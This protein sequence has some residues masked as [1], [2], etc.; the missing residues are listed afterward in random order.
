MS[1]SQMMPLLND[2]RALWQTCFDDDETFVDF[3]FEHCASASETIVRYQDGLPIGHIGL[4]HY[5]IAISPSITINAI[6]ISGA[7]VL[8]EYRQHGV[9]RQ[10]MTELIQS[11]RTAE[12]FFLIP[13][14]SELRS[15]YQRTFG[16]ETISQRIT[17][18]VLPSVMRPLPHS[19]S[20]SLAD[21][22]ALSRHEVLG[23]QHSPRQINNIIREYQLYPYTFALH[24][25]GGIALGRKISNTLYIDYL[26]GSPK[27]LET[28]IDCDLQ[29]KIRINK[30][31]QDGQPYT[32]EPWGMLRPLNLM[33]WLEVWHIN[34]PNETYSFSYIDRL[35]P[36]LSGSY[37]INNSGVHFDSRQRLHPELSLTKFVQLFVPN[38]D[39]ALLHE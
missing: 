11:E 25:Q 10:M 2:A 32:A 38:L 3:Y 35:L 24:D 6:Y 4:P 23:I 26:Y 16:F 20:Q 5:H 7:C 33:P 12:A 21:T 1:A 36:H 22:L 27:A 18:S 28:L 17:S 15:Y 29:L 13:A 37:T 39:L 9:M 14:S 34:N 30:I 31:P 8:P 19:T